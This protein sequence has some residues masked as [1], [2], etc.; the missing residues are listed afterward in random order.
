MV[1]NFPELLYS[2]DTEAPP[3]LLWYFT[4]STEANVCCCESVP[5]QC[6]IFRA[7]VKHVFFFT[8]YCYRREHRTNP[9]SRNPSAGH[10]SSKTLDISLDIVSNPCRHSFATSLIAVNADSRLCLGP[11]SANYSYLAAHFIRDAMELGDKCSSRLE[12]W[13][14]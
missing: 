14:K 2:K 13:R 9:Q 12:G 10:H 5:S 4:Q 6:I 7:M 11:R 8:V 3:C 1:N